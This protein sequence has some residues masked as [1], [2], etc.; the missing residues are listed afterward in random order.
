MSILRVLSAC[1]SIYAYPQSFVSI[2]EYIC[3]S[4]EGFFSVRDA[5]SNPQSGELPMRELERG[6]HQIKRTGK[7]RPGPTTALSS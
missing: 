1:T 3:L 5:G 6:Q 2:Y 4:S 7:C